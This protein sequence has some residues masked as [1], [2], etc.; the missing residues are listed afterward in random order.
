MPWREEKLAPAHRS[1]RILLDPSMQQKLCLW[2][3]P[4]VLLGALCVGNPFLPS[5]DAPVGASSPGP[6]SS[7]APA[8]VGS[9]A[10]KVPPGG[11]DL[12]LQVQGREGAGTVNALRQPVAAPAFLPVALHAGAV[13]ASNPSRAVPNPAEVVCPDALLRPLVVAVERGAAG[14]TVWVL[15]DGRR[16]VRNPRRGAGQPLLVRQADGDLRDE[17]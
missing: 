15:G 5:K 17:N 11:R 1:V 8:G 3:C 9:K 2:L 7:A 6:Q 13:D 4:L 16:F 12:A 14:E 10:D